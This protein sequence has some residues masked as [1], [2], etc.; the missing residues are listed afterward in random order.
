MVDISILERW[1]QISFPI[2]KSLFDDVWDRFCNLPYIQEIIEALANTGRKI[3]YREI[4]CYLLSIQMAALLNEIKKSYI[5]HGII[6]ESQVFQP[7]EESYADGMEYI[8]NIIKQA[9]N[10]ENEDILELDAMLEM[11]EM[12][13]DDIRF[14]VEYKTF[15]SLLDP[16][17]RRYDA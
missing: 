15:T 8:L 5:N 10:V 7:R 4:V 6:S 3:R 14:T 13:H 16:F 11:S 12:Y 2:E 9:G 17:Q 1:D